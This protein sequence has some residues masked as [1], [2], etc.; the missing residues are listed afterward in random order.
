MYRQ[1][2]KLKEKVLGK[3]YPSTRKKQ[4]QPCELLERRVNH[5]LHRRTTC[6]VTEKMP[7]IPYLELNVREIR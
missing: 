5:S 2:L 3:E 7:S 4:P 1:A 6:L